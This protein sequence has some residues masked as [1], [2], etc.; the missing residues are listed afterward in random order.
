MVNPT[1]SDITYVQDV[2]YLAHL[3]N[4]KQCVGHSNEVCT[5]ANYN[6]L[7]NLVV[8]IALSCYK[9]SLYAAA[10]ERNGMI[11]KKASRVIVYVNQ[12]H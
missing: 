7:F 9:Y 3:L 5:Y 2:T 4:I 11:L 6:H 1:H 8:V 10:K 12:D